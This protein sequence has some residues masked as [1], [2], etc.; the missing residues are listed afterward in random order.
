MIK[1]GVTDDVQEV[2]YHSGY[3]AFQEGVALFQTWVCIDFYKLRIQLFVQDEI[4]AQYLERIVLH[5]KLAFD[6]LDG[7]LYYLDHA[8][9][10]VY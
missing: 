7:V 1:N 10:V 2:I 4:V 8:C 9:L 6:R 3:Q 5:N